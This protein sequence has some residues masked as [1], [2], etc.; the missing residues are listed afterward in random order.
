MIWLIPAFLLFL[1]V[2]A[3]AFFAQDFYI[4]FCE[5][6]ITP[7]SVLV[8]SKLGDFVISQ[9]YSAAELTDM[10]NSERAQAAGGKVLGLAKTDIKYEFSTSLDGRALLNRSCAA[11]QIIATV[12]F[13][14]PEIYMA[15]DLEI[16]S[17]MFYEVLKHEGEHV[18]IYR[19]YAQRIEHTI[20]NHLT[21]KYPAGF[22]FKDRSNDSLEAEM[23]RLVNTELP[24]LIQPLIEEAEKAQASVDTP[25]E[26]RRLAKACNR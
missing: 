18:K 23:Q 20:K 9:E 2:A 15:T 22:L 21:A 1:V 6:Q 14:N 16:Q 26:Y 7:S 13:T 12:S 3:W 11:P 8:K 19:D 25:E 24:E 17:C 10:F 5:K 4:D